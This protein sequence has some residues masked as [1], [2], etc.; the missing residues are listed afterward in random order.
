MIDEIRGVIHQNCFPKF[1]KHKKDYISKNGIMDL[2]YPASEEKILEFNASR[3]LFCLSIILQNRD[4]CIAFLTFA[5]IEGLIRDFFLPLKKMLFIKKRKKISVPS[6]GK[7]YWTKFKYFLWCKLLHAKVYDKY[8][9]KMNL[10]FSK[11]IIF[12]SKNLK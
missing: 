6:L 3:K 11:L 1:L 7:L 4:L 2:S 8:P 5:E 9:E 10:S 12:A